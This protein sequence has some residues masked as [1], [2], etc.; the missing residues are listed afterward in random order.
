[1]RISKIKVA[2]TSTLCLF[3]VICSA[4]SCFAATKFE[5]AIKLYNNK[6]Y[7]ES[8]ALLEEHLKAYPQDANASY[9]AAICYQQLGNMGSS[10]KYYRAV[11]SLSPGSTIGGYARDILKKIDP[12]FVASAQA[13]GATGGTASSASQ[14][15]GSDENAIDPKLP[16]ECDVRCQKEHGDIWVEPTI[17][18]RTLRMVL[19]TGAP[20]VTVGREQ[21]EEIGLQAPTGKP[22]GQTGG[23]SNSTQIDYWTMKAKVKLGA[24]EKEM[25]IKVLEKN[26]AS[27]LLGQSFFK[28][29]EYTIDQG[30]GNI[31]FR[32]RGL[33]SGGNVRNSIAIPFEFRK[34]AGSR[35]VVQLEI[36]G[37]V[38]PVMFDTGNSAYA[39]S[40][41]SK[42][43][44]EAFG[45]HIPEDAETSSTRGV[46]GSGS[47]KVFTVAH[48]RLGSIDKYNVVCDANESVD[49]DEEGL[50][51]LGEPF[52]KDYQ[53]TVDMKNK[54][55]HFV[56]R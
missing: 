5:E 47:V 1:M 53:Y 6:Q 20:G 56:R 49:G 29:F 11:Y 13:S 34:K 19:D 37:K 46:S 36:N 43:Q 33:N 16:K 35:I 8:A 39:L 25:T 42:K 40:F 24:I 21:L 28:D 31:H 38:H 9:W 55:L 3:G 27:P 48:L 51:L 50:P 22:T 18:G 52:W 7:R 30:A 14:P 44:A 32:Q 12:S 41:E 17:N 45:A 15:A 4:I 23:S 10:R 54:I 26:G 2:L